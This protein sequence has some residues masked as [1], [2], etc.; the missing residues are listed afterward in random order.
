M[1]N[2]TV[3]LV[4]AMVM[5]TFTTVSH[6]VIEC[7]NPTMIP[8]SGESCKIQSDVNPDLCIA[9]KIT[10]YLPK[11]IK[12]IVLIDSCQSHESNTYWKINPNGNQIAQ[13]HYQLP[14]TCIDV[15]GK[16]ADGV[17]VV[18][19]EC[20]D[21]GNQQWDYRLVGG[22]HVFQNINEPEF[23]LDVFA[24]SVKAGDQLKV[25]KCE[26]WKKN[27]HFDVVSGCK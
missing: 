18:V 25:S 19:N 17:N 16:L 13:G 14:D 10:T 2:N 12:G 26:G 5:S 21:V 7:D 1:K 8:Y 23:C 20:K 11:D 27:Q 6:A 24:D 9:S 15:N 4:A 3:M 22:K